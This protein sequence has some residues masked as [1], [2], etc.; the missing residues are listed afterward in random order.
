MKWIWLRW[1]RQD[2]IEKPKAEVAQ[3]EKRKASVGWVQPPR[4]SLVESIGSEPSVGG[5]FKRP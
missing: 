5:F 3:E 1:L 2:K 4:K